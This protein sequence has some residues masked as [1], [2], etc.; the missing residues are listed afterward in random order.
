MARILVT[1]DSFQTNYYVM[2]YL[3]RIYTLARTVTRNA[4]TGYLPY[5][6][7]LFLAAALLLTGIPVVQASEIV[8]IV[9][10]TNRILLVVFDDGTVH[11]PNDLQVDRLVIAEATDLTSYTLTSSDD[12]AY[13][14]PQHPSDVG[15]KTKGTEF[16]KDAPWGGNSF[17]PRSKP[18]A[19]KHYVYLFLENALQQGTSYTLNTGGLANNGTEWTFTY[20]VRELRSEAVHVNTIGYATDAPKYGYIYH[21]MGDKGGLDLTDYNGNAFHLYREGVAEPVYSGVIALRKS[22]TNPETGQVNDTPDRNFLG[23]E[24]YECDFSDVTADGTYVLA[25]EEIGSSYPFRIGKDALW[26]AY[27]TVGRALFH[28]RSG[29]RLAPPYTE[30][31]YIRPVN[32]NTKVTSDDGTDF[33]GQLLYSDYPFTLWADGDGGGATQSDIRDAAGGN[34]IDVAGWYHDAGDWD[35]YFSHQR[36]PVLLMLTWEYFPERFADGDLDLPESGNGI[37]DLVDEASWLIKFNY[38]LR[39]ELME[40][41]FTSGGVGGARICPDV[42]NSVE[43]NAQNDK[44]SW[45]DHRHYVVTQADAFMTYL[46]AGQAAQFAMILR[47]LGK[48]P[49]RFPVEMLDAVEFADMTRDTVDWEQE[50]RE[51]YAWASASKNQPESNR[52]YPSLELFRMYA[53]ANLYRLT[54]DE[55]YHQAALE[56]LESF[57]NATD[58][59]EDARWGC[60][61]YLLADNSGRD[62]VLQDA[63]VE[64]ARSAAEK[65]GLEAAG[66][67][68]CRWGGDFW[69]P[70]L[71]GQGTTPWVFECIVA[72]GLTGESRYLDVVHTTADYFLGTNPLHTTWATRLGPRPAEAGFHLDSRYNNNWVVYPGFI[73]YGPWSMAFGYTPYTWTIDGVLY[74]GGHGPWNKDWANFSQYPFMEQWPGHERWNSNIHAPMSSENT[75]HQNSVYGMLTYGFANS[76]R[77]L[78]AA[79]PKPVTEISLNATALILDRPTDVDTLVATLDIPDASIG[80]LRWTSSNDTI[81]YV[82]QS[83]RVKAVNK[84]TCTVTVATLDGSVSASCDITCAWT[85]VEVE[86]VVLDPQGMKLVEGQFDTLDVFFSPESA[87]EKAVTWHSVQPSIATVDEGGR[88]T[89]VSPGV[90]LI[91]ATAVNGT[92][93]DTCVVLV[94]EAV[95]YVIADF[96]AVVPT[97][98]APHPDSA[99]IYTPGEG[100]AD[101]AAPNPLTGLADPSAQVVRFNRATG[102]W[103]LLGMVLPTAS[104]HFTGSY[105]EFSFKYYGKEISSLYV[106]VVPF[107]G[108]NLEKTVEVSGMDAW[109][110]FTMEPG[111]SF[112]IKQFNVFVN[113]TSSAAMTCYFDDFRFTVEAAEWYTGTGIS[114]GTLD[115]FAG[116]TYQ[117]SAETEG[118]PFS[119]VSDNV[120]VATVD[121]EGNVTA[122]SEGSAGIIALPLY[123]TSARCLVNVS[124]YIAVTGI[125]IGGDSLVS[126]EKDNMLQLHAEIIP[127]EATDPGIRWSV[128]DSLVVTVDTAGMVTAL[129]QGSAVVRAV[130]VAD[131]M[132]AD[133]VTV[134]VVIT[135]IDRDGVAGRDGDHRIFIYP[136]PAGAWLQV[137]T[138]TPMDRVVLFDLTGQ[139]VAL[140]IAGGTTV[141]TMEHLQLEGGLYF[142]N[143][144][145]MDGTNVAAKVLVQ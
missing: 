113:P 28:Q 81:A 41:Q 94:K 66:K 43:G 97:P 69:M 104:A 26:D 78:N 107:S 12:P 127:A 74:E 72:F 22:A 118:H 98:T 131:P 73:P 30:D 129:E 33:A 126:M 101:I 52:N 119:W 68:A 115:L 114:N 53:A 37:P 6:R 17:D 13:A 117:L 42:Y 35:A 1:W 109:Q 145:L 8:E 138:G 2:N 75:V 40:K 100:T 132:V 14:V 99:Q 89:A 11:Y 88:V 59:S 82:D 92:A 56:E 120:A 136:N 139:Q 57:R 19:A 20:D 62:T 103:R 142:M 123:G 4:A 86:S 91:V 96:D 23:G 122:L 106:Q 134:Q 80:A 105:R 71:V 135:G 29:I 93:M 130:A 51:A 84:G 3:Y 58:L 116:D 25:V 18:W 133:S 5:F 61:S 9:P 46:Y 95:D 48:D 140:Y 87:T 45:K 79:A 21:W 16:V 85:Y 50:A 121:Q 90:A 7:R 128:S 27:Y 124:E 31:G 47:K 32:Q 34:P 83:G 102:Q 10:V 108:D 143:I 137:R 64:V 49:H 24:V 54:D 67:R 36:I 15:R 112:R 44:P 55:A 65:N 39:K 76:R 144:R 63:L 38:R 125:R 77:N 60:Y 111:G 110:L 70:M 141:L